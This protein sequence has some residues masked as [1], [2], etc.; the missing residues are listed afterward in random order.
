MTWLFLLL[1]GRSVRF[2]SD[3]LLYQVEGIPLWRR[4][5]NRILPLCDGTCSAVAVVSP[6]SAVAAGVT[7]CG[8]RCVE[9]PTP[10]DGISS[11]VRCALLATDFR[12]GDDYCFL[13]GDQPYMRGETVR[14]FL[15]A[16]RRSG[17]GIGSVSYG[18][19]A[20]NP[21]IFSS[22]YRD[23]LLQLRGDQGGKCL[24]HRYPRDVFLYPVSRPEE[25]TDLDIQ[26]AGC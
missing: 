3:K 16:F 5:V 24:L 1:A 14:E 6:G 13:V 4:T 8:I 2:G 19:V 18:D 26:P 23:D 25:L 7:A 11:S 10:E 20:G 15:A 9:N 22:V 17:K 12:A 21:C